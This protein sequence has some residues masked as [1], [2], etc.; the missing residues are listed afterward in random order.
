LPEAALNLPAADEMADFGQIGFALQNLRPIEYP[1]LAQACLRG[2]AWDVFY[3]AGMGPGDMP[4][5]DVAAIDFVTSLRDGR[6]VMKAS[7]RQCA[8]FCSVVRITDTS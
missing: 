3:R 5:S 2:K 1:S 8:S 4:A 6:S 7:A